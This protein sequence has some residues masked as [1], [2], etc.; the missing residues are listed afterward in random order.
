VVLSVT[1]RVEERWSEKAVE[2]CK[3]L[4]GRMSKNEDDVKVTHLLAQPGESERFGFS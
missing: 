1:K 2:L 4:K 3:R